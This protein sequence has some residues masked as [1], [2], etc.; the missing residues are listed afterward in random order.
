M[1][2][3]SNAVP[4][5]FP[6]LRFEEFGSPDRLKLCELPKP[7]L[8]PDEV[9][10]Q[11]EAAGVNPSDVKNVQ[12]VMKNTTLPRI[13]GRDFAGTVIEGPDAFMGKK[14]WGTGGDIGFT[15]DGSHSRLLVIPQDAV[16]PIPNS[17]SLDEAAAVGVAYVTAW[18]CVVEAAKVQPGE[19]V[20]VIGATGAVG[21]A[22]TQ[23]AKWQG[24]KVFNLIRRPSDGDFVQKNGAD[25]II[26]MQDAELPLAVASLTENRGLNVIIDTVGGE[27]VEKCL[28]LLAPQGRLTEISAPASQRRISFDL[29][30]FY[31]REARLIGVDSRTQDVV[32]CAKILQTLTAGFEQGFLKPFLNLETYPLSEGVK[33]YEAVLNRTTSKKIILKPSL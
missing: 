12:G 27:W 25:E 7:V 13:P 21:S 5:F 14:V 4:T 1:L 3:L 33:A 28:Q 16:T 11:V 15:R 23:I 17:L 31:R 8:K 2:P 9:L 10:I 22:A 26:N 18:L 29:I 30:D 24:A 19:T 20:L 6:A 32:A